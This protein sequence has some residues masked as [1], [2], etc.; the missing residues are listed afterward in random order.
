MRLYLSSFG[1]GFQSKWLRDFAGKRSKVG[2]ILNALDHKEASR[3]KFGISQRRELESLGFTVEELD[4]RQYFGEEDRLDGA[5]RAFDTLWVTGGNTFVLRRAMRRSGFD[6]VGSPLIKDGTVLYG[7]FSAGCAVLHPD[8]RGIEFSDDPAIVPAEYEP[9]VI[10]DGLGLISFRVA[11][12]Y[13]SDH[14]ETDSTD[15]EIAFY[16]SLNLQY[17]TL[18]DGEILLVEDSSVRKI[19]EH[20]EIP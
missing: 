1:F 6:I 14:P 20:A 4:L 9:E 19:A 15:R 11:V 3:E 7:G 17:E 10:W 12:H 18:R 2:L 8:L 5:L 13:Q 16:Q